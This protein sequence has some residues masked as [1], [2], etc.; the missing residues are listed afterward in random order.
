MCLTSLFLSFLC[1]PFLSLPFLSLPFPSFPFLSLAFSSLP[2]PL[3]S[4]SSI[5]EEI[6]AT[7]E[8]TE[9]V[10]ITGGNIIVLLNRMRLFGLGDLIAD[11][12]IIAWS[13]GA[14]VLMNRIIL[15]HDRMPQGKR[16]AEVLGSG[17][18]LIRGHIVLPDPARRL[19]T[20]DKLRISFMSRRFAP[21][22]CLA[23]DSG[24]AVEFRQARVA[25][26]DAVRT[27]TRNGRVT[28]LRAA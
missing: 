9:A 18:G 10:L 7:L 16:D 13:A 4:L 22:T 19:R 11:K 6:A 14:M 1:L 15:F 25:R 20:R 23:L 24:S 21:D 28:R 12:P 2:F 27:L 17:L 26:A 5:R 8:A 3:F